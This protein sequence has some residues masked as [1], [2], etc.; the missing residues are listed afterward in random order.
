M[1]DVSDDK[2]V[3]YFKKVGEFVAAGGKIGSDAVTSIEVAMWKGCNAGLT[4]RP[5][6][7]NPYTAGSYQWSKWDE[8]WCIGSGA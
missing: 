5:N 2:P 8:G 7:E 4:R 6:T 3:G 1:N